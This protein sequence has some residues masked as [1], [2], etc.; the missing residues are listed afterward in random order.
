LQRQ[1]D[2]SDPAPKLTSEGAGELVTELDTDIAGCRL[3]I[4][5]VF[6]EGCYF[7]FFF[8]KKRKRHNLYCSPFVS[9]YLSLSLS[10]SLSLS[11]FFS[12]IN[13]NKEVYKKAV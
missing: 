3:R 9:L 5:S 1:F 10:I 6:P 7:L 11:S 13:K 12:W 2:D 4:Q 8:L